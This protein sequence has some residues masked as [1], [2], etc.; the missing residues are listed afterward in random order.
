MLT[1]RGVTFHAPARVTAL[2]GRRDDVT[3][4]FLDGDTLREVRSSAVCLAVGRR[5][6]PRTLGADRLPLEAN[7]RGLVTDSHRRTSLP[8]ACAAGDAAGNRQLTTTAAYEGRIAATNALRGDNL[9]SDLSVVPQIPSPRLKSPRWGSP[10]AK[11]RTAACGRHVATHDMRGASNGVATGEEAGYL[12][13]VS[14]AGPNDGAQM[15]LS[16][17]RADPA[18]RPRDPAADDVRHARRAAVNPPEPWRAAHQGG[19]AGLL[20]RLRGVVNGGL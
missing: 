15:V 2:A 11:L 13:L 20:R 17:D 12:K 8:R 4:R 5:F 1:R 18:R 10:T 16:R 3:T 6:D 19:R 7:H 9:A 14:K